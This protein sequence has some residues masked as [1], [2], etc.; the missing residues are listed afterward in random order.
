VQAEEPKEELG[1]ALDRLIS[2]GLLF[3]QGVPPYATYAFKHALVRDAAYSTLL[4]GRRQE[5]HCHIVSVL[6]REF[7]ELVAVEPEV[8]AHHVLRAV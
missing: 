7:A 3:R 6:Q 2:V 8:L 1:L 5:L 4:R